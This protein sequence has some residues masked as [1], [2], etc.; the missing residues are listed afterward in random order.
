[1]ELDWSLRGA[2]DVLLEIPW[3]WS[4]LK[5]RSRGGK[6]AEEQE[7]GGMKNTEA[8]LSWPEFN[9][10]DA[11][12]WPCEHPMSYLRRGHWQEGGGEEKDGFHG[13]R[14]G[15]GWQWKWVH[16]PALRSEAD[17]FVGGWTL[18][19][20]PGGAGLQA[21]TF[22]PFPTPKQPFVMF[23][24]KI[25]NSVQSHCS[26]VWGCYSSSDTLT[27]SDWAGFLPANVYG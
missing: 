3:T 9:P 24:L 5:L 22:A 11:D 16:V 23:L 26:Q 18:L 10:K 14:L 20:C 1:M 15:W 19:R 25:G 8:I 21:P 27:M 2:L 4:K 6:D 7:S 17:P 12:T 13:G